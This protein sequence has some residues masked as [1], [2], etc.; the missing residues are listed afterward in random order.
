MTTCN[1]FFV[2]IQSMQ[3]LTG[4]EPNASATISENP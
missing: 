4:G 2:G 1:P 3:L